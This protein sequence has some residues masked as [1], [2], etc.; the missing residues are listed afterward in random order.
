MSWDKL[1]LSVTPVLRYEG[2][3]GLS[4][5]TGFLYANPMNSGGFVVCLVTNVHVVTGSAPRRK[6]PARG[7]R[8]RFEVRRA[9]KDPSKVAWVTYPLLTK[10][11]KPTWT[12][13]N[14][15]STADVAVV[16]LPLSDQLFE[17]PPTCLDNA[18]VGM[19]V[20]S[21]PGQSVSV[22]G[23]PLG[24]RDQVN[25]APVWKIGHVAS[26]PEEDF[27]GEPRFLIDITGRKGLS[28]SPV[29][30]G[31]KELHFTGGGMPR[32]GSSGRLLGVYASN[33]LRPTINEPA[34]EELSLEE[35]DEEKRLDYDTRPELG[36]VWKAS[37]LTEI[38]GQLREDRL[39]SEL[40]GR[41]PDL[42]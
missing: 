29:V 2:E 9:G 34:S 26:E 4:Q 10:D 5:G 19:D 30:A 27:D 20:A 42:K 23:Y 11:R 8:I 15:H 7:D 18:D 36:F 14:V 25:K 28:G 37:V 41:L 38:L 33:A 1:S 6:L 22:I 17:E 12:S 40:W 39:K 3:K 24:W 21:Y 32:M 31:H 16:P 13:S 35:A